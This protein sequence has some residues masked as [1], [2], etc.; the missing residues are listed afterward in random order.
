MINKIDIKDY[1]IYLSENKYDEL[2]EELSKKSIEL[3]IEILKIKDLKV[4]ND[5]STESKLIEI[6][7]IIERNF[8]IFRSMFFLMNYLKN[9]DDDFFE[10]SKEKT[11]ELIINS[12]NL[13]VDA[14][15]NYKVKEIEINEKGFQEMRDTAAN[16]LRELYIEM[17]QFKN[18]DYDK[19]ASL[20]ELTKKAAHYYNFLQ[21]D[22]YNAETALYGGFITVDVE[23]PEIIL[24]ETERIIIAE[25]LISYLTPSEN[26]DGYKAYAYYYKDYDLKDGQTYSDLYDEKEE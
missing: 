5:N 2:F 26:D 17:L 24:N 6:E 15:Y 25:N 10:T 3:A 20:R 9:W 22:I 1:E 13:L 11:T 12:H 19:N 7:V 18:K 4:S 21:E 16:N 8:G 14:L 23:Q